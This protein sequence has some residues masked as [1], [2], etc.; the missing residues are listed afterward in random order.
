MK[1]K[2][3]SVAGAAIVVV[4]GLLLWLMED[5]LSSSRQREADLG[6]RASVQAV[7]QGLQSDLSRLRVLF[8]RESNEVL[9]SWKILK[10][11]TAILSFRRAGAEIHDIRWLHSDVGPQRDVTDDL[12]VKALKGHLPSELEVGRVAPLWLKSDETGASQLVLLSRRESR[13]TA[14]WVASDWMQALVDL[15]KTASGD[16]MIL[17]GRGRILAHSESEYA[18]SEIPASSVMKWVLDIGEGNGLN[19]LTW[20]QDPDQMAA[21]ERLSG[22]ELVVVHVSSASRIGTSGWSEFLIFALAAALGVLLLGGVALWQLLGQMENS[23][24]TVVAPV[25]PVPVRA[26]APPVRPAPAPVKPGRDDGS[27]RVAAVVGRELIGPLAAIVGYAQSILATG[28]QGEAAEA[29]ESVVRESRKAREVVDK[30]LAFSGEAPAGKTSARLSAVLGKVL[31]EYEPRFLQKQIKVHKNISST[32]EIPVAVSSLE[33]AVRHLLDNAI[34]AMERMPSKEIHLTLSETPE[35]VHFEL[36]DSGEGISS[37]DLSRV[38]E[39][40]F[41]TRDR[42]THMGMGLAAVQGVV[43][44]HDAEMKISSAPGKGTTVTLEFPRPRKHVE[45]AGAKVELKVEEKV[46]IP[47]DIPK[48]KTAEPDEGG[49]KTLTPPSSP[50]DVDIESLLKMAEE[51]GT[52]S[53]PEEAPPESSEEAE[54]PAG[55][56]FNENSPPLASAAA[57]EDRTVIVAESEVPLMVEDRDDSF[58]PEPE[59]AG[60]VDAPR[61]APPSRQSPLDD[62]KVEV[63]RPAPR[64]DG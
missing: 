59:L 33:S 52:E 3:L 34:E 48:P 36:R 2:I 63:R 10:P 24:A 55:F 27:A 21:Y 1:W 31:R 47:V 23:T 22:T 7:S 50:A 26:V 4:S 37:D 46:E 5:R 25:M 42:S 14:L 43:R 51:S 6:L 13:W 54:L 17:D 30:L 41:T 58:T 18:G 15:H 61:F 16:L 11:V 8:D 56:T 12:A 29:A 19:F 62:L 20:P 39:A 38:T 28:P 49:L 53:G 57:D 44:E 45:I 40:F 9:G 60:P 64:G 32:S 35:A